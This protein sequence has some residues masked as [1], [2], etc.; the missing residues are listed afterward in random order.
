MDRAF[1]GSVE[2]DMSEPEILSW[3]ELQRRSASGGVDVD[4]YIASMNRHIENQR[5]E[6]ARLHSLLTPARPASDM[7][8]PAGV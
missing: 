8:E 6:I 7:L 1:W 5:K 4:Q 3:T 2:E